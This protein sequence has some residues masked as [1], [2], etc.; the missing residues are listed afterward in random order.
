MDHSIYE[1]TSALVD[2]NTLA[3]ENQK[4]FTPIKPNSNPATPDNPNN[5]V[6]PN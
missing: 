6:I 3:L 5:P 4:K 2:A 1:A